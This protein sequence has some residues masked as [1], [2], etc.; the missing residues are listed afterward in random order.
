MTSPFNNNHDIAC[1]WTVDTDKYIVK[2]AHHAHMQ[3][4]LTH[5]S[6]VDTHFFWK[7]YGF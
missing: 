7:T 6:Y 3:Y 1:T 2:H 5:S 4:T